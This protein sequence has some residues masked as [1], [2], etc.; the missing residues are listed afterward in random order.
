MGHDHSGCGHMSWYRWQGEN[1]MRNDPDYQRLAR[2][3]SGEWTP[4]DL[5]WCGLAR[6]WPDDMPRR[7]GGGDP[8]SHPQHR[9][10]IERAKAYLEKCLGEWYMR[11]LVSAVTSKDVDLFVE[12]VR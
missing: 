12:A 3:G 6:L 10:R 9:E 5:M 7:G 4:S 1:E 11:R 2:D 8:A